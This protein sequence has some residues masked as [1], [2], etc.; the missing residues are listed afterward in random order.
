MPLRTTTVRMPASAAGPVASSH[1]RQRSARNPVPLVDVSVRSS[2]PPIA[3]VADG[4]SVHEHPG[5]RSALAEQLGDRPC[6]VDSAVPELLFAG[7]RPTPIA[8][9]GAG[10][11][12]GRV[13]R[14]EL[15]QG[16]T[17]VGTFTGV[18]PHGRGRRRARVA[19]DEADHAVSANFE[20]IDECCPDEAA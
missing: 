18:P 9:S 12:D 8:D 15:G 14:S 7:R 20:S 1:W 13:D 10:E 4:R 19:A 5:T 16:R 11:V 2:S 17:I 6:R 3:V